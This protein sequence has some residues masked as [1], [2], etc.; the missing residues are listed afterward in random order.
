MINDALLTGGHFFS[1]HVCLSRQTSIDTNKDFV[2]ESNQIRSYHDM[3]LRLNGA[4]WAWSI[5]LYDCY[6][7]Y[8]KVKVALRTVKCSEMVVY[9]MFLILSWSSFANRT[10]TPCA[11]CLIINPGAYDLGMRSP[12]QAL[13]GESTAM[14]RSPRNFPLSGLVMRACHDIETLSVQLLFC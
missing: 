9:K 1:H 2:S 12:L 4:Q 8:G 11:R 10:A 5:W 14:H 3:I 13:Y 7:L 6:F